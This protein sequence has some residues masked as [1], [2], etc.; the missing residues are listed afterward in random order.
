MTR[1]RREV[2]VLDGRE[3]VQTK[4]PRADL[5]TYPHADDLVTVLVRRTHDLEQ[6]RD[7]ARQAWIEHHVA[8]ADVAATGRCAIVRPPE[9]A[10]HRVGWWTTSTGRAV[11]ARGAVDEQ[12]RVVVWCDDPARAHSAGPGIEFR[13]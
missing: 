7:L 4:A 5:L 1:R 8:L 2:V 12:G 9:L 10:R 3:I 11:P 13:P 6:A